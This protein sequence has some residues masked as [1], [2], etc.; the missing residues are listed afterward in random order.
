MQAPPHTGI[1][2]ISFLSKGQVHPHLSHNATPFLPRTKTQRFG[3]TGMDVRR[4]VKECEG[5]T[6]KAVINMV[7]KH[8]EKE[9]DDV[10][11]KWR[12]DP[13]Q[14]GNQGKL[15][16]LTMCHHIAH[17]HV[18][19]VYTL[20]LG[21]ELRSESKIIYPKIL[22]NKEDKQRETVIKIFNSGA[23]GPWFNV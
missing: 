1:G 4:S 8:L 2:F 11:C 23:K 14:Q 17:V 7:D 15:F 22:L 19:E 5:A 20:S 10:A 12:E 13:K 21:Q 3:T 6:S 16:V 9:G 18:G